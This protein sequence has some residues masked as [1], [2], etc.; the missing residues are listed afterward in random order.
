MPD[1]LRLHCR[2]LCN[3]SLLRYCRLLLNRRLLYRCTLLGC[4]LDR[5]GLLGC[6]L[7]GYCL[8]LRRCLC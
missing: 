2:P 1:C 4:R 5:Y 7:L 6:C 3:G 8:L